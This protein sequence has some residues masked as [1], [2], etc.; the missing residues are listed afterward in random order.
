MRNDELGRLALAALIVLGMAVVPVLVSARP[1]NEIP[2]ESVEGN[3]QLS[4][5]DAAEWDDVPAAEVPLSSAPSGLPDA[6]DT[7]ISAVEVQAAQDGEKLYIRMHWRDPTADR[8]VTGPRGFA[9]AAAVQIPVNTSTHPAIAMGSTRTPVNVW[10][11]SAEKGTE[12][13]AAGGPS[14]TTSF[15]QPAVETD[16]T[17]HNGTYTLVYS[18]P[19]ASDADNRTAITMENNVDV[20]FA[21][22]NGSN[23]ERSGRKAVSEWYHFP[24]GPQPSGPQHQGLLWA[25]AG[26]AIVVVVAATGFAIKRT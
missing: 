14:T 10:Y 22:W 17:R 6:S 12:E 20:A 4:A 26:I 8:N 9:D 13:L 1:A 16:V 19:L 25:I 24:L 7:S 2:V 21:V 11:W 3:A 23:A 18:R 5:A 15:E